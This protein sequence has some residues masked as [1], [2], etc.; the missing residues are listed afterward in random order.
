M[1][2]NG[3]PAGLPLAPLLRRVFTVL[4]TDSEILNTYEVPAGNIGTNVR[5]SATYPAIE[6]GIES[7]SN[8]RDVK[9]DQRLRLTVYG[10]EQVEQV[11]L[12]ADRVKALM[13]PKQLSDRD[14]GFFVARSR[15]IRNVLLPRDDYG[16][17]LTM[18]FNLKYVV[19]NLE[20]ALLYCPDNP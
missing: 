17:S 3:Y 6:F 11:V 1:S 8:F 10:T 9:D 16:H 18:S 19:T 7:G 4:S 20:T 5:K 2:F 13:V 15:L 14:N 12:I